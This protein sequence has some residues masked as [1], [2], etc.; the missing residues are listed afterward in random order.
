MRSSFIFS[1]R[2]TTSVIKGV[3]V[4]LISMS[5]DSNILFNS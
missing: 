3:I 5:T 1:S 4:V 2:N